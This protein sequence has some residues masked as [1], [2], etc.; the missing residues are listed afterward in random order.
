MN[1]KES[2]IHNLEHDPTLEAKKVKVVNSSSD[3]IPTD[4]VNK[5][6]IDNAIDVT[7]FDLLA[8]PFSQTTNISN[9]YIF[10]NVELNFSTTESK[11]IIVS[12]PTGI[13]YQDT[14]TNKNVLV[15]LDLGYNGSNNL[16]VAVTQFSSPGT[17]DCVLKVRQGSTALGGNP[18]LGAGDNTVGRFKITD[19]T[20]VGG[21]TPDLEQI[22][23][24]TPYDVRVARGDV[25]GVKIDA[26]LGRNPQV[27]TTK[28]DVW[29]PGATLV[30]PIVGETW[31]IVSDNANDTSAGTGART[32]TVTYLDDAYVEQTETL[33]LNGTT[34]VTFVA[35][36][37]FRFRLGIV[38]TAGS[39]NIN[40]GGITIRA[41]GGGLIRALI[42]AGRG[43][44]LDGHYTVEAGKTAFLKFVFTNINKNEDIE[45]ELLSTIGD[46]KIFSTR[47]FLTIYQS[48]IVSEVVLA[49]PFTEKSDLKL[50]AVSTN[51]NAKA[52]AALQF[53]VFDN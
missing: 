16:T 51:T 47:F 10:D 31:E 46:G 9:D 19:G 15:P 40:E 4:D 38:I 6:S 49:S 24:S 1:L 5:L 50:V 3:P 34:P 48:S 35:T 26:L 42:I 45:L 23:L 53:Y 41:S 43:N 7:G 25:P 52:V 27:G 36:N 28:E 18:V 29:D 20:N 8:A 32:V 11:T 12:S 30:Y 33:T 14:N 39:G 44:T 17:M 2:D 13:I 37:A 22:T 21:V